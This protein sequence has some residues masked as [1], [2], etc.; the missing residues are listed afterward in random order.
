[1]PVALLSLTRTEF[2]ALRDITAVTTAETLVLGDMLTRA[3]E[4]SESLARSK[5]R[6]ERLCTAIAER[7][8]LHD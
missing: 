1:M 3:R 8:N 2:D 4:V 6:L 5:E 7:N